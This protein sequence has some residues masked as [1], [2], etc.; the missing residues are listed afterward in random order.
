MLVLYLQEGEEKNVYEWKSMKWK[1]KNFSSTRWARVC[2]CEVPAACIQIMTQRLS[3]FQKLLRDS[4]LRVYHRVD[5]TFNIALTIV[6][7]PSDN[8]A[9]EFLDLVEIVLERWWI[10]DAHNWYRMMNGIFNVPLTSVGDVQHGV[11]MGCCVEPESGSNRFGEKWKRKK[12]NAK[13]KNRIIRD[14]L[15]WARVYRV[16]R[17]ISRWIKRY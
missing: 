2:V 3:V 1:I 9:I 4:P 14:E 16:L 6:V 8:P 12:K 10:A 13:T 15:A 17:L 5:F 7:D 11:G